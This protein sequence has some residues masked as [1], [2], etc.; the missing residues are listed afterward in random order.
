MFTQFFGLKFNPFRKETPVDELFSSEDGQELNSRLQYLQQTRGIGLII[1][2]PGMGKTTALRRYVQSLN[3]ALYYPCYFP[4]ATLNINEFLRGIAIKLGETPA[5]RRGQLIEQIQS[6]VLNFYN[7]R[8]ITPVIV[9]DEM[10]MASTPLL[11]ELRLVFNF[12]MD[13]QNPYILILAA[14]PPIRSKLSLN[15]HLP[16]RQRITIK[17][18]MAGLR[19]EELPTYLQTRLELAGYHEP[20]FE[21][22]AI[23]AIFRSTYGSPRQ[24]NNLATTCLLYAAVNKCKT[25][26]EEAV[27]QAHNELAL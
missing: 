12:D 26:N 21:K 1:G 22:E 24:V 4:L 16:L 20:V 3:S 13:S 17:Y 25:V 7:D 19:E 8:K 9:L 6:A 2:E 5:F 14:Q 10:H 27:Y 18:T 15:V 23:T 11:D